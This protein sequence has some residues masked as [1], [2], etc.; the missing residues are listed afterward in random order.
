MAE[1]S[2]RS[3]LTAKVNEE[4]L[5]ADL[6]FFQQK[7]I[8]LGADEAEIIPASWV[9]VDERVRLKCAVPPCPNY[10]RCANCPPFQ[11][12]LDTI[13]KA[14][15]RY[16]KAIVFK[17]DVPAED[18]MAER[19]Y[20]HGQKWQRKSAEIASQLEGLAFSKGYCYAVGFGSGSCR[21]TLCSSL[22]CA[23][24]DSGRCAHL[25]RARPSIE[26]MGVELTGLL[27]RLGWKI[28]PIYRSSKP[29][30]VPCG[31][32]VGLTFIA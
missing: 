15:N 18:F 17:N 16:S 26:A 8:E 12:D 5:D 4:R 7:A 9:E 28:Y 27:E 11:F 24:L 10:R 3:G 6:G 2:D 23:A 14:F 20:P 21:D 29:E 22:A 30:Q 1:T 25:L 13:R 19:Y 32:T 31:T